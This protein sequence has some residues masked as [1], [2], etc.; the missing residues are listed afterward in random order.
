MEVLQVGWKLKAIEFKLEPNEEKDVCI[1][2]EPERRAAIHGVVKFP[3]GV[4]AQN[5]VV[6]LFKKCKGKD[7]DL[8]PVTFAFTDKCGQF[9]FGVESHVEYVVKVF[10]YKPEC[11]DVK[12]DEGCNIKK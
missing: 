10:F 3:N 2:L 1:I 8:E 6:K 7:C 4:P 12:D 5:A 11:G 9:L